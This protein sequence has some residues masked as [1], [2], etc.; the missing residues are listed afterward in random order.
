MKLSI[1]VNDLRRRQ[2][3]A[4]RWKIDFAKHGLYLYHW[5]KENCVG[6]FLRFGIYQ[7]DKYRYTYTLYIVALGLT[8]DGEP[9]RS[10]RY[11]LIV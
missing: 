10:I 9:Q 7:G 1:S 2:Q 5:D 6:S 4:P 8:K 11:L 3:Q